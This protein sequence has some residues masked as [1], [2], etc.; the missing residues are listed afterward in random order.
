MMRKARGRHLLPVLSEDSV[1]LSYEGL[2]NATRS[3]ADRFLAESGPADGR[4]RRPGA[5]CSTIE[6]RRNSISKPGADREAAPCADRFRGAAAAARRS[7]RTIR[8]AGAS[9]QSSGEQFN[10]W[11]DKSRSDVALLTT[12]LPTG[13]YP[14][15]GI[16]WF[17]TTFGRDAIVTA[18]QLLWLDPSLA[19]GVLSFLAAN[20]SRVTSE[21]SRCRPRQDI[22][23]DAQ[24]R[25]GCLGRGSVRPLFWRRR[26]DA[27]VCHAC[28]RVCRTYRR[29]GIHRRHLARAA[30]PRWTGWKAPATPTATDWSTIDPRRNRVCR[31]KGGRT[32]SIPSFTP[33]EALPKGR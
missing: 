17:A 14:Y 31:I 29:H 12:H 13:L 32:A 11:L 15:A 19:R 22:A 25:D 7:M 21:F 10:M 16:P 18:L 9:V 33:M 27:A 3:C 24:G 4:T 6:Q 5:S 8:R 23:R 26:H 2:D 28:R 20:Q 1:T 30:V